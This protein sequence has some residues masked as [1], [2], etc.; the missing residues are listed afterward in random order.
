MGNN[1]AYKKSALDLQ[2]LNE[3]ALK[4]EFDATA[5]SLRLYL[6]IASEY[7][8]LR[9]AV[10]FGEGYGP[11]LIKQKDTHLKRNYKVALSAANTTS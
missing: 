8:L 5:T 7:A 6:L 11:N 2:T 10:S 9:T 1:C 3:L 4:T